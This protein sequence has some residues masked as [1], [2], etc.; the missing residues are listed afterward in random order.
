[1]DNSEFLSPCSAGAIQRA[2]EQI[3]AGYLV[4][5]PTETVYGLGADAIN[6]EAV[7]RIYEVKGRP[8]NHPLIVHLSSING[9]DHWARDIPNYALELARTFWPGPMQ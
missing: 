5:F 8:T 1:M 6:E 2:A 7:K 9:L 3:K 4:A